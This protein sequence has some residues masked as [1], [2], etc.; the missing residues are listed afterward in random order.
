MFPTFGPFLLCAILFLRC[1]FSAKVPP[2]LDA[3]IRGTFFGAVVADALTLGTHYEYD[4]KRIRQFYG[5]I[6]RFFAPGERTGGETHGVGWGAR[7]C[8]TAF[9]FC[10][11]CW[12]VGT[13]HLVLSCFS[14]LFP[15]ALFPD[16][17]CCLCFFN[18]QTTVATA[19]V[20]QNVPGKTPTMV[21]T[22]CSFLNIW[23]RHT[24]HK[25]RGQFN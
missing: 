25:V 12:C 10:V 3:R 5:K 11:C 22:T 14:F 6:D 8:K 9:L 18:A 23:R 13:P 17:L 7:N 19:E 2:T 16:A 21:T 1:V 24:R 15:D 4:A 20:H